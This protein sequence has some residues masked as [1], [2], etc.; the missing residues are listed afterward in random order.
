[1]RC[2]ESS[3]TRKARRCR[4]L[5]THGCRHASPSIPLWPWEIGRRCSRR[6]VP[7]RNH[8]NHLALPLWLHAL[9]HTHAAALLSPLA[10]PP[11]ITA[12]HRPP[13]F[14]LAATRPLEERQDAGPARGAPFVRRRE[15]GERLRCAGGRGPRLV[16][17]LGGV[18]VTCRGTASQRRD[19][20]CLVAG[21][22]DRKPCIPFPRCYAD[23]LSEGFQQ[24]SLGL[25]LT[26]HLVFL[27]QH[28]PAH[29]FH[30]P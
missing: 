13:S 17:G 30:L 19:H 20:P 21:F 29:Q 22:A 16:D 14:L 8:L 1:M 10:C 24:L 9:F 28:R 12:C 23:H 2:P 7:H 5:F 27:V 26:S 4:R 3:E 25:F 15:R 18:I 6:L 11:V